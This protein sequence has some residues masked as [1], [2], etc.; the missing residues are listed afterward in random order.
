MSG[1]DVRS[2]FDEPDGDREDFDCKVHVGDIGDSEFEVLVKACGNADATDGD[3]LHDVECGA[4][5]VVPSACEIC[6]DEGGECYTY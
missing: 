5:C 6:D 3:G 2:A 4:L 1:D